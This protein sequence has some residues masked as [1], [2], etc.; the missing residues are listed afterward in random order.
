MN[1]K[2]QIILFFVLVLSKVSISQNTCDSTLWAKP[3][4][5]EIVTIP[6]TV[7]GSS[8][9]KFSIPD[10]AL[11]EI[12]KMRKENKIVEYQLNYCTMIRIY[13]KTNQIK[14]TIE[15]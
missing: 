13:P 1:A 15:K 9:A 4:T 8:T 11:C 3:G 10:N 6:G 5:Y 7:E 12:E 14:T 2:R